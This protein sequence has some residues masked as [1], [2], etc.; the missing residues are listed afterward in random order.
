MPG[1]NQRTPAD[2]HYLGRAGA[3]TRLPWPSRDRY[4]TTPTIRGGATELAGGGLV[5]TRLALNR[6]WVLGWPVIGDDDLD[7]LRRFAGRPGPWRYLD[8]FEPNR[9]TANQST[10]TDTLRTTNGFAARVQ[11]TVSSDTAV[12]KSGDRSLRWDTGAPLGATGR[13]VD[14][15]TSTS[16]IDATWAAVR[17][18]VAYSFSVSARAT[19]AVTMQAG[20]GWYTTAGAPLSTDTGTGVSLPTANWNTRLLCENKTAPASAAYAVALVQNS[21]TTGNAP[22]VYL[23]EP[24]LE[25]GTTATAWRLGAGTPLVAVDSFAERMLRVALREAELTLV[26]VGAVA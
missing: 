6:R 19:A 26:E 20:I 1:C 8:A 10:A 7:L 23:D 4:D 18:G 16:S 2:G 5:R 11:G 24:Q 22:L 3:L 9:L 13:G 14:L 17:G 15:A 21:A 25:E 12:V